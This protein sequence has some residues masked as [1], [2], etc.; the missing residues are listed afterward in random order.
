[1]TRRVVGRAADPIPSWRASPSTAMGS[2]ACR[3]MTGGRVPTI[4]TTVRFAASLD[5]GATWTRKPA[6]LDCGERAVAGSRSWTILHTKPVAIR[7]G[8]AS[9]DGRFHA[10]WIDNRTG[11]QQVWIPS[12]DHGG[13]LAYQGPRFGGRCGI[14]PRRHVL[15][16]PRATE[17][18]HMTN[19]S[20]H[21]LLFPCN[22]FTGLILAARD[23]GMAQ[24][25]TAVVS[26]PPIT[27]TNTT[28]SWADT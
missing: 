22:V 27:A 3:G 19:A 5:G 26:R 6:N 13:A 9:A 14:E 10:I 24:A 8:T 2:S 17:A 28:G 25:T 18:E 23:D 1:M 15:A 11:V 21:L 16:D 20:H 4:A 7:R 12:S